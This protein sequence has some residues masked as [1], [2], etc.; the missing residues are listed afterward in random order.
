MSSP[1][2]VLFL[3]QVT[4]LASRNLARHKWRSFILFASLCFFVGIS[5]FLEGFVSGFY[6]S[7]SESAVGHVLGELQVHEEGH[8]P[9]RTM[10]KRI[11]NYDDVKKKVSAFSEVRHVSARIRSQG[12]LRL[13]KELP[14]D[15]S[16]AAESGSAQ[17][18]NLSI[19]NWLG[20]DDEESFGV[21]PQKRIAGRFPYA[22]QHEIML[23]EKLQKKMKAELGSSLTLTTQELDGSR[24]TSSWNLVGIFRTGNPEFDDAL[25]LAPFAVSAEAFGIP[26]GDATEFAIRLHRG[27]DLEE[28]QEKLIAALPTTLIIETWAQ[29]VPSLKAAM[30]TDHN[31]LRATF[32]VLLLVA[33]MMMLNLQMMSVLERMGELGMMLAIGTGPFLLVGMLLMEATLLAVTGVFG[34]M[35]LGALGVFALSSGVDMSGVEAASAPVAGFQIAPLIY[36]YLNMNVMLL[37]GLGAVFLVVVAAL[38]PSLRLFYL[39]PITAMRDASKA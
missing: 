29:R 37:V 6:A 20:S 3:K 16:G 13:A 39:D 11:L 9:S 23:G 17:I 33:A 31:F 30:E 7:L 25:V 19:V 36:P 35:G 22:G 26:Q 38:L 2:A 18:K 1:N 15:A 4:R 10:G 32:F 14:D 27:K 5:V 21:M 8:L 12:L 24:S 28:T 34:G